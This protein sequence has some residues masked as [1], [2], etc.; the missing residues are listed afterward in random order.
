MNRKVYTATA[1]AV[2]YAAL[3]VLGLLARDAL[4]VVLPALGVD[5]GWVP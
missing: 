4:H 1:L 2:L 5:A 3:L